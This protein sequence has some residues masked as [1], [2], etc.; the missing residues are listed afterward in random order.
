[1]GTSSKKLGI[2]AICDLPN[3]R[4]YYDN[5]DYILQALN[6][7]CYKLDENDNYEMNREWVN[8]ADIGEQI[9][10]EENN[11]KLTNKWLDNLRMEKELN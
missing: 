11:E 3:F 6:H 5:K 1:M 10:E 2:S 4:E 7:K 8:G 9:M